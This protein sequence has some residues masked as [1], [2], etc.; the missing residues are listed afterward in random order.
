MPRASK[1]RRVSTVLA[2][3]A[4]GLCS[5]APRSH[6]LTFWPVVPNPLEDHFSFTHCSPGREPYFHT[7]RYWSFSSR[8]CL[9]TLYRL[10][11]HS[12]PLYFVSASA[13]RLFFRSYLVVSLHCEDS[14]T[15]TRRM[16]H[17]QLRFGYRFCVPMEQEQRRVACETSALSYPQIFKCR[18]YAFSYICT[19]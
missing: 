8:F 15:P 2:F 9:Y 4:V 14:F 12:D 17:V 1:R 18:I 19:L 5:P 6:I 10:N 3:V 7:S 11:A 13:L 16:F